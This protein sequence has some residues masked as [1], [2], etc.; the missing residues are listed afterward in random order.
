MLRELSKNIKQKGIKATKVSELLKGLRGMQVNW[1]GLDAELKEAM[2]EAVANMNEDGRS[3]RELA[4]AIFY[5]GN[6]EV[7]WK[8]DVSEE[9]KKR[10]LQGIDKSWLWNARDI[11]NILY[12]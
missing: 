3:T 12:G 6:L 2:I 1:K 5:L 4:N 10:I 8:E 7:S 9:R 11:S